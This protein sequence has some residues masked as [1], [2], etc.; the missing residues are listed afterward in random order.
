VGALH[1]Q[2]ICALEYV[3]YRPQPDHGRGFPVSAGF[4]G[5]ITRLFAAIARSI[6]H[7]LSRLFR[8]GQ[9][10]NPEPVEGP[11][12]EPAEPA[13]ASVTQSEAIAL[14]E[15]HRRYLTLRPL[16]EEAARIDTQMDAETASIAVLEAQLRALLRTASIEDVDLEI[17]LAAFEDACQKR[18]QYQ[19][20][21][22][23]VEEGERRRSL[24]M[25]GRTRDDLADLLA[26]HDAE[27]ARLVREYPRLEKCQT[28]SPPEQ[29]SRVAQAA[30]SQAH[31]AEV[32]ATRLEEDV[33]LTLNRFRPRAEIEEEIAHWQGEVTRL[34]RGRAALTI[35]RATIEEAMAS[36]YR[37]FAPAVNTF[38]SEGIA[39]ATGGRY[40]RAYVDPSTLRVS[41]LVPETGQVLTD[42]PVS[43]GTRTLL[44]VLMRIGLAQHMSAIGEPVPLILDDPFVDVDS[45]RLRRML[46]FLLTLSS[47]MQV[48]IFTK[49]RE[50]LSW[51]R[52]HAIGEA[53][54]VHIMSGALAVTSL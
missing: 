16:I 45:L 31:A 11:A 39:A 51:Y 10:D 44:Y 25:A 13:E 47:R 35:A 3:A 27:A 15:K 43:H 30:R 24:L 8:R 48:L 50:I 12:V 46:D 21:H 28:N 9:T 20:A 40:Q 6:G 5:R 7:L 14:L 19:K 23:A 41:L 22:D 53:H 54:Q 1:E 36:V 17:A 29:L 32:A 52:E 38:L 2:Q 42:P 4:W 18:A 34:E 33:R 26:E 49:D 37:D